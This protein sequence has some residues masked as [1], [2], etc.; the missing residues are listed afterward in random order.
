VLYQLSYLA[1]PDDASECDRP[2][3]PLIRA[4]TP[5]PSERAER[6]TWRQ[7]ARKQEVALDLDASAEEQLRRAGAAGQ[8]C[9]EVARAQFQARSRP[10]RVAA[11]DAAAAIGDRR[12]P[13]V[14]AAFAVA[15][16]PLDH[17]VQ[18]FEPQLTRLQHQMLELLDVP[19]RAY[20][21]TPRAPDHPDPPMGEG[22]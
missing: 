5:P 7:L 12:G 9:Q 17:R 8:E 20:L 6:E 13:D 4:V 21:S 3:A 2:C 18:T 1:E 14:H 16:A 15:D 22:Y 10:L 11:T 19:E